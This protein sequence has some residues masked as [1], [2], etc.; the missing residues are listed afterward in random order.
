MNLELTASSNSMPATLTNESLA[1]QTHV[2]KQGRPGS[3]DVDLDLEQLLDLC[4]GQGSKRLS[5][6]SQG[7][8]CSKGS[9][10]LPVF[11]ERP[12]DQVMTDKPS[13]SKKKKLKEQEKKRALLKAGQKTPSTAASDHPP[14]TQ[15]GTVVVQFLGDNPLGLV[16]ELDHGLSSRFVWYAL[17]DAFGSVPKSVHL[18]NESRS[19]LQAWAF[20]IRSTA[21]SGVTGYK[22]YLRSLL[23]HHKLCY[24]ARRYAGISKFTAAHAVATWQPG[25]GADLYDKSAAKIPALA[26]LVHQIYVRSFML[27]F[28]A[29]K[30]KVDV[31]CACSLCSF[32]DHRLDVKNITYWKSA[33]MAQRLEL[34]LDD[35]SDAFWP[36]DGSDLRER[37]ADL[38]DADAHVELDYP[39]L[40]PT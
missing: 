11:E 13:K 28:T 34:Q 3:T 36:K 24:V 5:T 22:P 2:V 8:R 40:T 15:N 37:L 21:L 25:R 16:A 12:S 4:F 19:S 39:T 29:R 23:T 26:E 31:G 38:A 35:T 30:D 10:P 6:G 7:S 14:K 18:Y 20:E 33:S 32:A 9:F 27:N 1:H 17:C